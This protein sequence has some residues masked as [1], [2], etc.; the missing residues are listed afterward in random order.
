MKHCAG[1]LL[2]HNNVSS[3]EGR[4]RATAQAGSSSNYFV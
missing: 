2:E 3:L 1:I 4:M